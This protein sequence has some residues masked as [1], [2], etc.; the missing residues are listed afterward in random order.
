MIGRLGSF[1]NI[2]FQSSIDSIDCMTDSYSATEASYCYSDDYESYEENGLSASSSSQSPAL[3]LTLKQN[4]GGSFPVD[5]AV[6]KIIGVD[7]SE[8][9]AAGKGLDP[10]AWVTLICVSFLKMFCQDEKI[11]WEL[12]SDKAEKFL[13]SNFPQHDKHR[14][15]AEAYLRTN[16]KN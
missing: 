10:R 6:A 8:M 13:T 3:Q 15:E 12:V 16:R 1:K 11:I 7:L 2:Y 4:A 5:D 14:E 9:I